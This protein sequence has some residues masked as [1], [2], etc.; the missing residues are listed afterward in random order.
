MELE[1]LKIL[2]EDFEQAFEKFTPWATQQRRPATM[3]RVEM[4]AVIG[5]AS[6][7]SEL[8]D[9]LVH[10]INNPEIYS[11]LGLSCSGG[12]LLHGPPGTG[13]TMLGR[14]AASLANVQFMAVSGPDFLSKWVGESERAVRELFQR[15]EELAPVVLFFD[16][17]DAVG[18]NRDNSEGAHHSSS[19]VAQ[20]L[21]MMDGLKPA[22]GIYFM[23][24]TN[25]IE[26]VDEAFLRPGRFSKCIEVGPLTNDLFFEFFQ[27][28]IKDIPSTIS[29][30]EW[31]N[32]VLRLKDK[33]TGAEL[34]GLIDQIK[35][36][37]ARRCIAEKT[38]V[39]L[40]TEDLEQG[41]RVSRHLFRTVASVEENVILDDDWDDDNDDE[42]EWVIP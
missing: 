22:D 12:V 2:T 39:C 11:S 41:L 15:A 1:G 35:H 30:Q 13:K 23:A 6:A 19:V 20:L 10:P 9:H 33:V 36:C 14:A 31:L 34:K 40:K 8:I 42:G 37:S 32:T 5:H 17:F 29:N 4:D 25:K 7:K 28:Q 16:E 27:N 18:R 26:L 21:T 24:S 38:E 3:G